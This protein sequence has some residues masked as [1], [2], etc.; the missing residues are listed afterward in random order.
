VL[1]GNQTSGEAPRSCSNFSR[2]S[3]GG[4]A[5]KE[6]QL[7]ERDADATTAHAVARINAA[8]SATACSG[9][10]PGSRLGEPTGSK[11]IP[12]YAPVKDGGGSVNQN[13]DTVQVVNTLR[14]S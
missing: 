6:K 4:Q 5:L 10:T 12:G 2:T 7:R 9:N 13:T 11:R 1:K 3:P 8:A 14:E